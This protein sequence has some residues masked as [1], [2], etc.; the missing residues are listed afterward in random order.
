[1]RG[2]LGVCSVAGWIATAEGAQEEFA[3]LKPEAIRAAYTVAR[4]GWGDAPDL[5]QRA[6]VAAE[7]RDF[8]D[9]SPSRSSLTA[10]VGHWYP[11]RGGQ[12]RLAVAMAVGQALDHADILDWYVHSIFLGQG[13]FG[14][15]AAAVAYFG[16]R[17]ADLALQEVAYLAALP[18]G[19]ARFHPVREE[20][21]AVE[22]RNHVLSAMVQTGDIG[23]LQ[24]QVSQAEPLGV[25][26]PLGTCDDVGP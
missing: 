3:F 26:D 15:D 13:C 5:V 14:V 11:E 17:P 12:M 9:S 16:K 20:V 4:A 24:A 2:S 23:P 21:R 8:F 1:M 10:S 6:F 7:D 19:P 22:R 25:L 18:V